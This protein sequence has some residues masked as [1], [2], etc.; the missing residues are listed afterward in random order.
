MRPE[1][2]IEMTS[3]EAYLSDADFLKVFAKDRAAWNAQPAWR[4]QIQKKEKGLW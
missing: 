4:K 2:G 3:K 1:S